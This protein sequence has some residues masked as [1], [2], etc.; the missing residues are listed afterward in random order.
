M[1][2]RRERITFRNKTYP[3]YISGFRIKELREKIQL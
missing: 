2:E 3:S 1:Q